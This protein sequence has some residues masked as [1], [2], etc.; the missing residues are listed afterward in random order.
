MK[1]VMDGKITPRMLHCCGPGCPKFE[2]ISSKQKVLASEMI[3]Y[4]SPVNVLLPC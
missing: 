2:L 4:L 1:C 3:G